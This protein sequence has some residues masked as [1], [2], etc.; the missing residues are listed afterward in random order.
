MRYLTRRFAVDA[1]GR[2]ASIEQFLGS[3]VE[4]GREGIRW[5]TLEPGSDGVSVV[6]H[7]AEVVDRDGFRD[8]DNFPPLYEDE[9]RAWGWVVGTAADGEGA[10]DLAG[11]LVGAVEDR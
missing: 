10:L 1:L 2:G 5:V 4:E 6:E 11:E 3:V 7:A 8:L 9:S